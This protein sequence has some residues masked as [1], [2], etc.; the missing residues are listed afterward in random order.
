MNNEMILK[1]AKAAQK[2]LRQLNLSETAEALDRQIADFAA[3]KLTASRLL[4]E[5][6][7]AEAPLYAEHRQLAADNSTMGIVGAMGTALNLCRD[8]DPTTRL[9]LWASRYFAPDEEIAPAMGTDLDRL[10]INL[11]LATKTQDRATRLETIKEHVQF[12]Q[13]QLETVVHAIR[14]LQHGDEEA[15]PTPDIGTA[16]RLGVDVH[17]VDAFAN[18]GPI[19]EQARGRAQRPDQKGG[20]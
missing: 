10:L 18:W 15:A 4:S 19:E 6:L 12:A 13:R 7:L 8:D 5:V 11:V 2:A 1:R 3:G 9:M 20:I 17:I 16:P 14:A